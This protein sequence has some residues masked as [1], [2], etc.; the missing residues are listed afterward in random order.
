M[1]NSYS[2]SYFVDGGTLRANTPSYVKRPADDELF[3]ALMAREFCYILTPRQM[4]KSSLMIRTSQRL[5]K[6]NIK[7]AIVDIQGIGTDK[8]REWY[9]SLL[10]QIR[11]GLKLSVDIDEWM[12]GK[13]NIGFGQLFLD[14][15]QDVVLAQ[16]SGQVVIF[17]DEVDWM[18]KI[19]FRDDF[20][21]SIR[22]IYNARANYDEFNRISFVLLG[23]ASPADLISEPT[24]TPFN[25]GH[26]IPLQE[27]S[28]E[29]AAPLEDG[30]ENV[31]S[32]EGK[33]ILDR[34][35]YWTNGHPYLTQKICKT[36]AENGKADWSDS[37][38]DDL[39]NRLFLSE[40]SRKEANLKFIQD[41]ILSHDQYVEL[42]KLYKQ[43]LKSKIKENGQS[44]FQ[45]QL[46]LSG[47]LTSQ[48]G[49]LGTR[50]RIYRTVFNDRWIDQNTPKNWQRIGFILTSS[51][52]V[53]LLAVLGYNY[54]VGLRLKT[55][56]ADYINGNADQKI[57]A[58][59]HIYGLKYLF[60]SN[61]SIDVT[62]AQTFYELTPDSETQLSLFPQYGVNDPDKQKDLV[63]IIGKLYVT[64]A[65]VDKEN[66][67]TSLL[68]A[69]DDAL[70][71]SDLNNIE[72]GNKL[73]DELHNWVTGRTNFKNNAYDAALVGYNDAIFI[74]PANQA[75]L[76]ERAIVLMAQGDY[77]KALKDLDAAIGAAKQS[78]PDIPPSP[79]PTRSPTSTKSP[80][81]PSETSVFRV[82]DTLEANITP[83]NAMTTLIA[84]PN[85]ALTLVTTPTFDEILTS[86]PP[87]T[88]SS[89]E[90]VQPVIVAP[91]KF[92]SNFTT[93]NHV[94]VAVKALIDGNTDLKETLLADSGKSYSNLATLVNTNANPAQQIS[95]I[96]VPTDTVRPGELTSTPAPTDT[97]PAN[98]PTEVV[99]GFGYIN[100][101][102]VSIWEEPSKGLLGQIGSWEIL[103]V[104]DAREVSGIVW[105]RCRWDNNGTTQEGWILGEYVTFGSAPTTSIPT[106]GLN[107]LI[108]FDRKSSFSECW[109]NEASISSSPSFLEGFSRREDNYW[110]F[111]VDQQRTAGEFI[112]TDFSACLD[113]Q[114][115]HAIAMNVWVAPLELQR[116]SGS[117]EVVLGAEFGFFIENK[118]GQKREYTIGLDNNSFIHLRVR[119][120]NEV[121][122]DSILLIVN[123]DNLKIVD[124]LPRSY[125]EFPVQLYLEIDSQGADIIYIKEGP[126]GE[127][128]DIASL[129]SNQMVQVDTAIRPTLGDIR[130]IGLIG[131]GGEIQT[132]IWPLV[133]F[134]E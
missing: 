29:D 89:V 45:N 106:L 61:T 101:A 84:S 18:I 91:D 78:A 113:G 35:F 25:I 96:Q 67:N 24:R 103:T 39:V 3:E 125:A 8:V 55:Y 53:L 56:Q 62:A 130:K 122:T 126:I 63:T 41:R 118:S 69:M 10:S 119:E 82:T 105:Y 74:N 42:L 15:I 60:S 100:K 117:G 88:N 99:V 50:N 5:R 72:N 38:V 65:N 111:S 20:F 64:L 68:K 94:I 92:E 36:I 80:I 76:Y 134:G 133:F 47:L 28:R 73:R 98:T 66:D 102:S 46:L 127:A 75:T 54:T 22:S 34:V 129:D 19:D 4:G 9:A 71:Y 58:L 77:E 27:L 121:T 57:T 30:L 108:S 123:P 21:A 11:R 104:L 132:V 31:C 40:E 43:V 124:V 44:I 32:G 85:I 51:L 59:A 87:I 7:T 112:Q 131:Y 128:V 33:R 120:N 79:T 83:E 48:E 90:P 49:L 52:V 107:S 70:Q 2:E 110:R 6:E 23:V 97:A 14:F 109:I 37:D 115:T 81:P 13:S 16:I 26:A 114:R 95:T 17:M 116:S 86:V 12:K 1:S 93:L